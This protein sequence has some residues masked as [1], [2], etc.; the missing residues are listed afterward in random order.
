MIMFY[1]SVATEGIDDIMIIKTVPASRTFRST[2]M[3]SKH[4]VVP[5]CAIAKLYTGQYRNRQNREGLGEKPL[6]TLN[7]P[8]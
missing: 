6:F 4:S 3:L 7:F 2:G 8:G 1:I 5:F